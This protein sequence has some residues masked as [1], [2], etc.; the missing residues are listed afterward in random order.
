MF[1]ESDPQFESGEPYVIVDSIG[2]YFFAIFSKILLWDRRIN[3][4][5]ISEESKKILIR[6]M[7][8][9]NLKSTKVRFNQYA[10]ISEWKRLSQNQKIPGT[11]RYTVGT[12]SLLAYTFIPDRVFAGIIG[13]DHYNPFTDTI[14]VYSDVPVILIHEGGHAKDF[15]QR[16]YV[17]LYAAIYAIPVVGSLYHEARA[18]DD[19]MN[20]FAEKNQED[21]LKESYEILTPAYSTYVGGAIGD[22]I[23]NP[24]TT[25]AIIPGHIYGR[26]KKKSIPEQMARRKK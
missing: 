23:L 11:L 12:I 5:A 20:Y 14:N 26:Y 4:H 1:S 17:T 13:G 15:A 21:Q 24:I 9:N 7:Q 16:Q 6:Y 25:A 18:T 19:A 3:N 2:S 8:E 10:P 22:I